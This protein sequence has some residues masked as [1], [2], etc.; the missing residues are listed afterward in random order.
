VSNPR[1]VCKGEDFPAKP[2]TA[3][4]SLLT[5]YLLSNLNPHPL[6]TT[7]GAAPKFA[8]SMKDHKMNVAPY[9]G[10]NLVMALEKVTEATMPG[11]RE[12]PNNVFQ[13]IL[14]NTADEHDK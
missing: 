13:V 4:K 14:F 8:E 2:L 10:S 11:Q 12:M 9:I 6:K 5:F 1:G 3:S 7:K